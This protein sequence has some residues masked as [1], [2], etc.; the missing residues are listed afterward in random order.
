MEKKSRGVFSRKARG[1]YLAYKK[2]K[3]CYDFDQNISFKFN[4]KNKKGFDL[5]K[6]N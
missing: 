4:S 3:Q 2:K 6:E 1:I 5:Q